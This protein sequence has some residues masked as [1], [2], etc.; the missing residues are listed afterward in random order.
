M[1]DFKPLDEEEMKVIAAAR[2]ELMK[3][4]SI[5]CTGC[6]YCVAGCPMNINIPGTFRAMNAIKVF[7]D[8]KMARGNYSFAVSLTG[9]KASDCI[10]CGQ[11]EGVCPQHLPIIQLLGDCAE[12]FD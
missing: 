6:K 9:G 5:Q 10:A 8:E 4:D 1:K 12:I 2:A 11:C 3:I 7:G